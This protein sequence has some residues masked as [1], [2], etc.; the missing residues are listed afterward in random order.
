MSGIVCAI[1]GGPGSQPTI[2]KALEVAR[3]RNLPVYFLYVF[4][5]DFMHHTSHSR[6]DII[7][8][9]MQQMGEFILM[10]AEN[11][12]ADQDV[13]AEGIMRQGEVAEEISAL[14]RE[15]HADYVIMGRPKEERNVFT[16][17]RQRQL[18]SEIEEK[19]GAQVI[20]VEAE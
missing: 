6:A 10:M 9:D 1:R 7:T 16:R 20:L 12:A 2:D 11:L 14:G 15:L 17:E 18:V 3:R 19:T 13:Q 8:A 5:L 4:N